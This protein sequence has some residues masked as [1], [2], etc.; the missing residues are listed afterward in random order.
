MPKHRPLRG[1][2]LPDRKPKH[3]PLHAVTG[4]APVSRRGVASMMR[5]FDFFDR[6]FGEGKYGKPDAE[7]LHVAH[8]G[9][10]LDHSIPF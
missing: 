7:V 10:D 4:K 9:A 8:F 2:R 1:Y 5:A 6:V 3:R